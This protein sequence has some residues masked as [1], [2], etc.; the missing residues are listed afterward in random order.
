MFTSFF[1]KAESRSY[2]RAHAG[3][4]AFTVLLCAGAR[5]VTCAVPLEGIPGV[6]AKAA[7]AC[8]FVFPCMAV[9]FRGDV[10]EIVAK[11]RARG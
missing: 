3:F 10:R 7:A 4:A 1:G 9:A 6:F 5:L 2:W 8:A 11:L